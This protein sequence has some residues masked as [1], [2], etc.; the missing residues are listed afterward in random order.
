MGMPKKEWFTAKWDEAAQTI[1][2][3]IKRALIT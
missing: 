1:Q 3:E 2:I